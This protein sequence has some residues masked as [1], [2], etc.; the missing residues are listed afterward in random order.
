MT[1]QLSLLNPE[2]DPN[3]GRLWC[4][5]VD[6]WGALLLPYTVAASWTL[7]LRG[8]AGAVVARAL[9]ASPKR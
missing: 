1:T 7:V 4:V 5:V 6:V 9:A 2:N 8:L 3:V